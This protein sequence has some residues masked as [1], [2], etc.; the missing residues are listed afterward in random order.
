MVTDL[1][2]FTKLNCMEGARQSLKLAL[3]AWVRIPR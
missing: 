1:Q 2:M 3:E